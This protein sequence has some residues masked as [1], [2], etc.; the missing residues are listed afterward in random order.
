MNAEQNKQRAKRLLIHYFETTGL[1]PDS[2]CRAEIEDI[3]DCIVDAAVAQSEGLVRTNQ[4]LA[5]RCELLG[6]ALAAVWSLV[7]EDDQQAIT[8]LLDVRAGAGKTR[9]AAA[10]AEL[11]ERFGDTFDAAWPNGFVSDEEAQP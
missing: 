8:A 10:F 6:R 5:E 3:V 1:R 2:D 9:P 4:L 11:R 7:S